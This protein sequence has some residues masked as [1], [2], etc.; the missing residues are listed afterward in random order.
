MTLEEK[1]K[2]MLEYRD[3]YGGDIFFSDEIKSA[4]S[5]KELHDI[6]NKYHH[7]LEDQLSDALRH[8]E[9]FKKRINVVGY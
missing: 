2:E 6:F 3:F 5:N 4:K 9:S 1:K 8:L 7:H